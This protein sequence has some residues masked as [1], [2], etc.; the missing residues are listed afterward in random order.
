MKHFSLTL[1]LACF[2]SLMIAQ[3]STEGKAV[4]N[5]YLGYD[6]YIFS[7][8]ISK[9]EVVEYLKSGGGSLNAS[10]GVSAPLKDVIKHYVNIVEKKKK[11]ADKKNNEMDEVHAIIIEDQERAIA[12]RYVRDNE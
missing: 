8:P 5:R 11:K 10:F 4:V 6:I 9:Y 1:I 7:E 2:S 12:I 3:D